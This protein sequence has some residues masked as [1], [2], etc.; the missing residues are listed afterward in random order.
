[1]V[2]GVTHTRHVLDDATRARVQATF[3]DLARE[4][5]VTFEQ[6]IRADLLR[7]A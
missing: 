6:P 4:G 7:K 3:E 2:I 1:M 5:P